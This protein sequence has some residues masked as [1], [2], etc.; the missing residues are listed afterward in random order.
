MTLLPVTLLPMTLLL[1]KIGRIWRANPPELR[2]LSPRDAASCARLHALSFLHGWQASDF[3]HYAKDPACCAL[4]AFVGTRT[5]VGAL[6]ARQSGPE[7]EILTVMVAPG[8]R[9]QKLGRNLVE[10]SLAELAAKGAVHVFLEVE[11]DNA[12]AC[13]L[14]RRLAFHEVG[15]RKA[16]YA[17]TDGSKAEAIIMR[18]DLLH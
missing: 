4:G 12:A 16:Y 14:Y 8:W 15:R 17:Q 10:R 3:E 1:E 6:I 11:H 9:G 18:R 7:A 5:L 13:A 2:W